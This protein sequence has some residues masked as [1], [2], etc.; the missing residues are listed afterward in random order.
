MVVPIYTHTPYPTQPN[1]HPF[2]HSHG[3]I[4][5]SRYPPHPHPT[6]IAPSSLPP[7]HPLTPNT[8][9]LYPQ[10]K[11][12]DYTNKPTWTLT[13]YHTNIGPVDIPSPA[14]MA[15][16]QLSG[17]RLHPWAPSPRTELSTT[18]P[19]IP[20]STLPYGRRTSSHS[21]YGMDTNLSEHLFI[22]VLFLLT[23]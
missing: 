7:R 1:K 2:Q 23:F 22:L 16:R 11:S 18:T 12:E 3:T 14:A 13:F 10:H 5:L 15:S 9:A 6:L 4:C 21:V 8:I 20:R 17:P 19:V